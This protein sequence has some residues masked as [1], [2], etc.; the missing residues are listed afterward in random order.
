[1]QIYCSLIGS[2]YE[3]LKERLVLIISQKKCNKKRNK[4]TDNNGD[5][6]AN[7]LDMEIIPKISK[8]IAT[9]YNRSSC[10]LYV[11]G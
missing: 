4:R 6:D 5:D 1:M 2:F 10:K 9:S 11:S 3:S 7:D 8:K